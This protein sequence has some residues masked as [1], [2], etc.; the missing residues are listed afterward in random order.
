MNVSGHTVNVSGL[1]DPASGTTSL[2]A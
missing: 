2:N 1:L